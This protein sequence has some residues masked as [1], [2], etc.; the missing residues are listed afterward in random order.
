MKK[1]RELYEGDRP[2][3]KLLS[4]GPAALRDDELILGR[5]GAVRGGEV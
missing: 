2:R 5:G 3:E 4:R 1:L